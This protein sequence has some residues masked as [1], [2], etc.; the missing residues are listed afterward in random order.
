METN[1]QMGLPVV[2]T[3]GVILF[4]N[5]E[6]VIDVGRKK[7]VNALVEAQEKYDS[8]VFLVAQKEM[9]LEDP[10]KEDVYEMG[11]LCTIEH[12][13]HMDGY[14]RVKFKGLERAVLNTLDVDNKCVYG[15]I[16]PVV[17][18]EHLEE[19]LVITK[20]KEVGD[21]ISTEE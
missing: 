14:K 21:P 11:T 12:V 17:D 20:L 4:P 6:I 5:Q 16:T 7:S 1:L 18:F 8:H 13:R 3:R 15:T 19:V 10:K 2:C 9:A